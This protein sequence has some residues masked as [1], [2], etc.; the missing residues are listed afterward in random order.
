MPELFSRGWPSAG[1]YAGPTAWFVSTQAN[2][3]IVPWV[4][5]H[6]TPLVPVVALAMIGLSLLGGFLSWRAFAVVS[7][8]PEPST[9]EGGR[10]RRFVALMGIAMALLF[11]AVIGLQGAAGLTFDGC[12]R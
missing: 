12:E 10:P 7:A 9:G 4:C 11:A 5:A 8:A 2:Y 3:A 1:L 6:Q